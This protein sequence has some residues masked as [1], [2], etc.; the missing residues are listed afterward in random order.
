MIKECL[1][2]Q[3][4]LRLLELIKTELSKYVKNTN[5]A[6]ESEFGLIKLGTGLSKH[7]DGSTTIEYSTTSQIDKKSGYRNPLVPQYIDRIVKVGI[8]T[9]TIELTDEEKLAAQSW[10]G[11]TE[12]LG[13]IASALDAIIAIQNAL[14]KITF[15]IADTEYTAIKGMTWE[16]WI[17]S[18]Y[19]VD[20][21]FLNEYDLVMNGVM[22]VV[23]NGGNGNDVAYR[24]T[25]VIVA[26]Y[27]YGL[28]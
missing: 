23:P 22:Y 10:L 15:K 1:D 27:N 7:T 2:E 6:S 26:N 9:N 17:N 3:G 18:E 24:G 19:N 11:I 13:D 14:L 12:E 8:T 16:E 28:V 4:L 21:Y 20:S 25:D 5:Y